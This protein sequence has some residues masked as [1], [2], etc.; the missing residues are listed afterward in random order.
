LRLWAGL[1]NGIALL[2]F[3]V[4]IAFVVGRRRKTIDG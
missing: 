2:L 4:S 1:L 3:M